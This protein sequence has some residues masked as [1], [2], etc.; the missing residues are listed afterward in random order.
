VRRP[1][2]ADGPTRYDDD[3]IERGLACQGIRK[4]ERFI[5]STAGAHDSEGALKIWQV[6][7]DAKTTRRVGEITQASGVVRAS[8]GHQTST[9]RKVLDHHFCIGRPSPQLRRR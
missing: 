7:D 4:V 6:A 8:R 3:T 9:R 5:I 2:Y 1:I